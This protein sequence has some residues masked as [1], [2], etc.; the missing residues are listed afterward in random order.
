MYKNAYEKD[1]EKYKSER[2][3]Y[4][5]THPS[6]KAK[7]DKPKKPLSS[8]ILFSNELREKVKSENPGKFYHFEVIN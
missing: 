2:E 3:E 6:A 4:L 5:Q 7:S 8:Y 1:M